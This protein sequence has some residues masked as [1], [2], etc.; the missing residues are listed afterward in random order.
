V[1]L[2][3]GGYPF[4]GAREEK[5]ERCKRGQRREK[6]SIEKGQKYELNHYLGVWL[7]STWL[8]SEKTGYFPIF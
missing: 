7:Y 6:Q 2:L 3:F 5:E 8:G 4:A 1:D